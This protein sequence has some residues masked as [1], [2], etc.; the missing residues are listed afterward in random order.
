[1]AEYI[2]IYNVKRAFDQE[3][4]MRYIIGPAQAVSLMNSVYNNGLKSPVLA[5][6]TLEAFEKEFK[7]SELVQQRMYHPNIA[8]KVISDN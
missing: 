1:M 4:N 2:M 6:Y 3:I 8:W 7:E 5:V